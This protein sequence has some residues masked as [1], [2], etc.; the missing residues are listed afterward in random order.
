MIYIPTVGK[1]NVI[2]YSFLFTDLCPHVCMFEGYTV[3][4]LVEA[5]HYNLEGCGFGPL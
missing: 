5:L 4:H 3:V 1:M 2:L